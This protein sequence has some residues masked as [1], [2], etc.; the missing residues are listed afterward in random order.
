[1]YFYLPVNTFAYFWGFFAMAAILLLLAAV[2]GLI[3]AKAVKRG[4]P[5]VP[6]MAIEEAR[7]IRETVSGPPPPGAPAAGV[8][9]NA[10]GGAEAPG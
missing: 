8:H 3:A 6:K 7:K 5:P 9:A 10:G 1:L 2:A 4:A